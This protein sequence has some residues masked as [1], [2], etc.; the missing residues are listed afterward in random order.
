MSERDGSPRDGHR[1][2]V[3]HDRDRPE[4]VPGLVTLHLWRVPTRR[5]PVAAVRVAL[6]RLPLRATPGVRF[7][8]LLGTGDG[9]TLSLRDADP[10][11]WALLAAWTE[12]AAAAAFERSATARRWA[13]LA[14]ETWRVEL[15]PL[16]AQGRWARRQPFGD[17]VPARWDGPV[18]AVTRARL[19]VRR[20]AAFWRSVPPVSAQLAGRPGLRL[21]LGI[22]ESPVGLQG[23]FSVWDAASALRAFAYAGPHAEAIRQTAA[24]RWY[25]EQLFARFA[26][27]RAAGTVDGRD[28]LG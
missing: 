10:G 1:H 11:R 13:R 24:R 3:H 8:K 26:V 4:P 15:R 25:A 18:A 5:V 14:E 22:G 21:A 20:A 17:P 6:D 12:P 16:A 9:R 2:P 7:A 19:A 28:P 23:T 27:L